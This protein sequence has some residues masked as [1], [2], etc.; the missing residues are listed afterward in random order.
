MKILF[1]THFYPPHHIG[2][3]ENYTHGLAKGLVNAG[4]QV[5]V[6][7][8]EEWETGAQYWNGCADDVYDSVPVR[9]LNLNWTRAANVNR[10]LYA[11]P[12][13]ANYLENY[14][15]A[16]K[17]DLVHI[18][19]CITLSA[20][21]IAPIKRARLPLVISL[22]DFWF[23][24]PRVTLLR[25]DQQ[26]CDGQVT[27]W[28]CL[29]CLLR[30]TKIEHWSQRIFPKPI[31]INLLTGIAKTDA[32]ARLPGLRGMALDIHARRAVMH[33][34]LAQAD[35]VL[36]ASQVGLDL[37]RGAG[38]ALPIDIVHY[39]HDL[40]WLDAYHGKTPSR[41]IRFGFSGQIAPM[42]GPQLLI[43]S[44]RTIAQDDAAR[45]LIYGNLDKDP[46]FGQHLRALA[47]QHPAIEFRGTYAHTAS[48]QVF[49]EMD[50]LV[51]PSLWNDYPLIINEAFATGT[52]VIASD[53]GGMSEFVKHETNGLLF[54]R[55]DPDD[56]ARQLKR[57]V[58]EPGLLAQL[59]AHIPPVKTMTQAV[60]EMQQIYHSVLTASS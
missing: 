55:G 36:I 3:T 44:F 60:V 46:A 13:I 15:R 37:F 14:L 19:S 18:T 17:P 28:D 38:F 42:K 41:A 40:S 8:V 27:E 20:S 53:F 45:L 32:F 24:C 49:G 9:R 58:A 29:E 6:L 12:F 23:I 48:A 22:T 54:K 57:I 34:A 30:G 26:P 16:I 2:G 47:N 51:V 25:S 7:C 10:D 52:P 4:H 43:E 35:R 1:L 56:L 21:V 11:N 50:V 31:A 39:G 5:Q 33:Q 59:R